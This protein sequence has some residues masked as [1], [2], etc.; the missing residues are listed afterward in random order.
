MGLGDQCTIGCM[1]LAQRPIQQFLVMCYNDRFLRMKSS[2]LP[3]MQLND[4]I[5][6]PKPSASRTLP[7]VESFRKASASL[8]ALLSLNCA[9]RKHTNIVGGIIRSFTTLNAIHVSMDVF[10]KIH[11]P[12]SFIA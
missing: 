12:G 9:H 1:Y 7:Q 10:P 5:H 6:L 3:F 8:A 4:K 11:G 2:H